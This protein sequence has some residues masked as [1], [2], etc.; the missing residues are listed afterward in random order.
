MY[1]I[2][3][4]NIVQESPLLHYNTVE[5]FQPKKNTKGFCIIQVADYYLA[6]LWLIWSDLIGFKLD[7]FSGNRG[8]ELNL[9]IDMILDRINK[10]D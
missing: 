9:C 4:Y 8:N 7:K 6:E 10:F 2:T 3:T 5:Q 1:C